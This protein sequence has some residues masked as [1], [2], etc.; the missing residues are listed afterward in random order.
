MTELTVPGDKSITHRALMLAALANGRST[1]RGALVAGDTRSTATVLRALSCT[2]PEVSANAMTVDGVGLRGLQP[3]SETL[4]C[5]NSGT[6]ARLLLGVVAGAG[7]QAIFDGDASLRTRPMARVTDPLER[8]GA[9][10]EYMAAAG[11]LPLRVVQGATREIEYQSPHASA[12]IKSALLLAGLLGGAHVRVVE[13]YASRDH[14]ERMLRAVGVR[15]EETTSGDGVHTVDLEPRE[16]TFPLDMQ[17]PGDLSSAAFLL[18]A[19]LLGAIGPVRVL[20]VGINPTRTGF[21]DVV[22]E[23]G[24]DLSIENV[25]EEG[26]EPVADVMAQP[27][28]LRA[29]EIGGALVPR[30]IDEIPILAML[31]VRAAGRTVI[32]DAAE[33]RVKESDRLRMVAQNLAALGAQVEE[34]ADGLVIEG[35][36]RP[37]R[38]HVQTAL[39]H[40]IAMSFGVLAA[41][42]DNEITMDDPDIVRISFP[43]FWKIFHDHRS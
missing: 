17:V 26:G 23:M 21:L 1:I 6:T 7:L 15:I 13:P 10:F 39:D 43:E 32:R 14:S 12:Q 25:R 5:G 40:R 34:R 3:P 9:R 11:K 27:S 33:L 24:G 19:A 8:M 30:L 2:I 22:R 28:E 38:G 42:K 37:L 35:G 29:V 41:Q 4:D 31:A 18:S 36:A 20:N 16:V